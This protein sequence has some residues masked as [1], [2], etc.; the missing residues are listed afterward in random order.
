MVIYPREGCK[1]ECKYDT[2]I[3]M[4]NIWRPGIECDLDGFKL[5]NLSKKPS[6]QASLCYFNFDRVS[7]FY[8]VSTSIFVPWL[9]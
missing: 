3:D 9:A 4:D 7:N 8:F 5:D 2:S 1:T 6:K